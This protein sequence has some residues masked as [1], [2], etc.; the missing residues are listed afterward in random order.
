MDRRGE[1]NS[2]VGP[3]LFMLFLIVALNLWGYFTQ[4]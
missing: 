2:I 3:F 4:P 1:R